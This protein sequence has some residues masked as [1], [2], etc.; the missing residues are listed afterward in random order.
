MIKEKEENIIHSMIDTK[1]QGHKA[2]VIAKGNTMDHMHLLLST[3]PETN[4]AA[5]VKEIKG[6]TSYYINQKT[7]GNLYWQD[8]YGVISVNRSGLNVVKR[9]VENQKEHHT[10]DKDIIPILEKHS[11]L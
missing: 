2:L 11:S 10:L 9:Y 5:L 7:Q 4:I 1:V 3:S 8:G 6:S